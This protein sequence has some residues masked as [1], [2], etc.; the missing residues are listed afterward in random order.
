MNHF[1]DNDNDMKFMTWYIYTLS[2]IASE[3]ID[4]LKKCSMKMHFMSVI[5]MDHAE[6]VCFLIKIDTDFFF[7]NVT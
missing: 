2:T 3:I 6:E 1:T 5:L 7:C 4:I